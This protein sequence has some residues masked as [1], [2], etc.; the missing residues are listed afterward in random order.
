MIPLRHVHATSWNICC[1]QRSEAKSLSTQ[2]RPPNRAASTPNGD[3]STTISPPH[4]MRVTRT[5]CV[6]TWGESG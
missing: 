3:S 6:S 5:P 1:R 4:Q 2:S